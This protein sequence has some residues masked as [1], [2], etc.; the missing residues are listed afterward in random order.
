MSSISVERRVALMLRC[1]VR[2]VERDVGLHTLLD[3]PN[4]FP[5]YVRPAVRW[6]SGHL[7]AER[8]QNIK[9]RPASQGGFR[10]FQSLRDGENMGR[11]TSQSCAAKMAA[12]PVSGGVQWG[13]PLGVGGPP[14]GDFIFWRA[15]QDTQDT[16]DTQDGGKVGLRASEK[17]AS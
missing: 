4:Q 7:P 15:D 12:F 11:S 6:P 1:F 9:I 17:L 10:R 8:R 2:G 16:Q 5:D 3:A 13:V 14:A